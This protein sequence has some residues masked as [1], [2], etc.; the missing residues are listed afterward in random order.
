MSRQSTNPN[1]VRE[2]ERL[3]Q[4]IFANPNHNVFDLKNGTG[5]IGKSPMTRIDNPSA[6]LLSTVMPK[7]NFSLLKSEL[8]KKMKKNK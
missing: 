3:T 4:E 5:Q 1:V 8:E 2:G 6:V 7:Q